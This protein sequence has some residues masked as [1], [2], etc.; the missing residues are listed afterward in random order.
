MLV[1]K[2]QT[3]KIRVIAGAIAAAAVALPLYASMN[4]ADTTSETTAA[5]RCLAWFG[6]QADGNCLSY[7]NGDGVSIGSP[8]VGIGYGGGYGVWGVQTVPLLP[9]T[10]ISKP[11]G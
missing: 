8:N 7:S 9:G 3:N 2:I 4:S 1:S 6:N 11:I 10:T 5:P